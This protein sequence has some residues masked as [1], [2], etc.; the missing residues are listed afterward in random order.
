MTYLPIAVFGYLL[1]SIATLVDKAIL[2]RDVPNPV[3]YTFY[4]GLLSFLVVVFIPLGF[5]I[6]SREVMFFSALSGLAFILAW[7]AFYSALRSDEASRVAPIVGTINPIFTLSVGWFLLSQRLSSNQIVAFAILVSGMAVLSSTAWFKDKI[8]R[9]H[10]LEMTLAGFLFALSSIF[11]RQAFLGAN[12]VTVL[13]ASRVSVG[14]LVLTFLFLPKLRKQ[15]LA[16][17]MSRHSFVNKTSFLLLG[18]QSAGA[19]GGLLLAY[20]I[21]LINPAIV[22]AIQGVQYIFILIVVLTLSKKFQKL[23]DE[24]LTKKVLTQ[25]VIGSLFIFVG[26]AILA[27]KG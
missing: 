21:S 20:A 8:E 12:F 25:K 10:L 11:L 16:S 26:L 5:H 9:K 2:D 23:L 27:L 15:I 6:P 7:L 19:A 24:D 4:L 14:G 3:V 17:R 18:G 1:D 22:N 13:V